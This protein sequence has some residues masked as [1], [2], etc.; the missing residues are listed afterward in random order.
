MMPEVLRDLRYALR[1]LLKSPGFALLT[2]VTLALGIGANT[3]IFS[4]VNA[5]LLRPLPFREPGRLIVMRESYGDGAI[6]TVSGPNFLDWRSRSRSLDGITASRGVS[7]AM[8]GQGDPEEIRGAQVS[9]EFFRV[10]GI[11]LLLGRGFAPGEDQGEPG[12][13]VI[14][15]RIWRDRFSSDPGVLKQTIRLSGREYA[16]VGVA[17]ATLRYPGRTEVW[18]PLGFGTGRA[19]DRGSHSYDVVA[20]LRPGV[21][22]EQ[23]RH[24]LAA[25]ARTLEA[26][27]PETNTGRSVVTIPLFEDSTGSVRPALML[28]TGAVALVL[29]IACA[30]VANLFLARAVSRQRE[31]AVR[32]AL[33]AGRWRLARQV[34][35]EAIAL[36]AAGCLLGLLLAGWAVDFLVAMAPAGIPRV[37]EIGLDATVL[38]YTVL[39]SMVVGIAFG[40]IPA[41]YVAGQDPADSFRGEGRGGSGT[42]RRSRLRAALVIAQISLALVLLVG[43]TLLIVS[44]RRLAGV[45]P[46]FRPEGVAT[47]QLA[48][49]TTKYPDAAAQRDF[50]DRL[51]ERLE[52]IPGVRQ[53]GGVF[54]LPLG[55]GDVNGDVSLEGSAPA[56]P[57]RE[58]IAGFR[59]VAGDYL[60]TVGVSLVRGRP[61]G[62]EDGEGAPLAAVVNQTFARKFFGSQNPIGRRVTFGS[63]DSTAEWREI[64][65][66]VGD[67]RHHGLT[68]DPVPEIYVPIRQLSSDFWSI[69][70]PIPLSFVVRSERAFAELAPEIKGAVRDVDPEQPISGLRE[71]E[72]LLSDAVARQRFS[73][74]L[75]VLF[76]GLALSLAAIGVYGV[77]AYAVSQRTRELGIRLAL[78]ARAGSV[79]AMVLRQGLGIALLGVALGIAGA[80]ALGR[81][82]TSLLYQVS[83]ADPRV[84][85]IAALTLSAVTV[86]ASLVP[87]IRATRV[88]PMDALRSE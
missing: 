5:V 78:G 25:I 10:L 81:L 51:I 42:R 14:G 53:A 84:L 12:V 60:G 34:L 74:L 52:R 77:M 47:F 62:R 37:R 55:T 20:R 72:E 45:D 28:L 31:I 66:V 33:G 73:M 22:L 88:D 13:A 82:L 38:G 40:A 87:A 71:A 23:A 48:L 6:G 43:A 35:A 11:D 86:L 80:L 9:A 70:V 57:G 2:I 16:I 27:Y 63:P 56:A 18:L 4:V 46:G 36:T 69:F 7:L 50:I 19:S 17:P 39:I 75:L 76:G 30:N 41:L 54:Y 15:E 83:P 29:L 49:S 79:R 24:D 67:V 21:E 64:V 59:L 8:V 65:G 32:A 1:S 68:A 3:A 26:E 44:V 58:L 61:L 85:G